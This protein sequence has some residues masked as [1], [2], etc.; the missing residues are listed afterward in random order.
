MRS[1]LYRR[2]QFM[3]VVAADAFVGGYTSP[4]WAGRYGLGGNWVDWQPGSF[5]FV[6][7]LRVD[8]KWKRR[9]QRVGVSLG[10]IYQAKGP[11]MLL[12]CMSWAGLCGR[13]LACSRCCAA[14]LS[15][16]AARARTPKQSSPFFPMFLRPYPRSRPG[17]TAL[18]TVTM[19]TQESRAL[20][21]HA[22]AHGLRLSWA[23]RK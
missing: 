2:E 23:S 22:H 17:S 14:E 13:R 5:N 9:K 19:E 6:T 3:M 11:C 4:G 16:P 18:I 10:I 12:A 1:C 7:C 20:H 21:A 15:Q 8:C